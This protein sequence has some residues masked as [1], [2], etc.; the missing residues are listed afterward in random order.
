MMNNVIWRHDIYTPAQE[1]TGENRTSFEF[2][3]DSAF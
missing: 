1:L 3:G 2:Q